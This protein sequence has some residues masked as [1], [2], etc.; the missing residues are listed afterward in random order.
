MPPVRCV[1][2]PRYKEAGRDFSQAPFLVIWEV[3]RACDLA[4]VHCRA[5][6]LPHRDAE[7]L[8]LPEARRLFQEVREMGTRLLVLTGGDPLKRTDI[9]DLIAAARETG[10]SPSLSPSATPLLTEAALQRGRE[11]GLSAVSLSLDGATAVSHDVFRG[12]S[13]SYDL[14]LRMARE[15]KAAGLELRIN[16]T[17]TSANLAEMPEI[18]RVVGDV[19][20]RIWSVFFLVP[21]GRAESSLQISPLQCEELLRWLYRLSASSP[22]RI[23]TTEAPHYRRVVLQ[24]MAAEIGK[25]VREVL[26][27]TKSGQG[28]F[29]AGMND[30]NGFVFISHRGDVYPSGFFPLAA[31]NVR[32]TRLDFLYRYSVLFR[33]LRDPDLLAGRCGRCAFRSLCGGSRARAFATTGDPLAEDPLCSFDPGVH[34]EVGV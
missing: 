18:A 16:T 34:E 6:A 14:T 33:S 8:T 4:C 21:T 31:G 10:L 19:G 7:E 5:D 29:V 22:F 13:G 24:T 12:V 26:S 20:A 9:F 23:K 27:V 30:A 3:T 32:E 25:T 28:R 2:F 11:A 15:V 17:V 1:D